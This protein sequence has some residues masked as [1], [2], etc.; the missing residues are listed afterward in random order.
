M[1]RNPGIEERTNT[2]V[3]EYA[4]QYVYL[5]WALERKKKPSEGQV[6]SYFLL[7]TGLQF[8]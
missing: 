8:A 3:Y 2:H 1:L 5:L 6:G 7:R 4:C